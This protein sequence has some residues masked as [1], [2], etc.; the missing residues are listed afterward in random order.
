MTIPTLITSY[1]EKV[2]V[3]QLWKVYASLSQAFK[4]AEIEHGR[5]STWGLTSTTAGIDPETGKQLYNLSAQSLVAQRI[6]PYLRVS[7]TC[8]L[9]EVCFKPYASY[10]LSGLKL[11]TSDDYTITEAS[12]SPA[13]ANFFLND[14]SFISMGWSNGNKIDIAVTLPNGDMVLG[15]TRFFFSYS[16][17]KGLHPEGDGVLSYSHDSFNIFCNPNNTTTDA[18][19]AC[20]AWVIYNKN[21]DYLHCPDKLSWDGAHSCKEAE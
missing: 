2:T 7:K 15:K 9:N 18:G 6:K 13:D 20:T 8:V 21:M 12:D 10:A 11:S 14:G 17:D 16:A 3:T 4:M 5:M 1:K 19:R